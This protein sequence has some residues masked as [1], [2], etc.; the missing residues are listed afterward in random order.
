MQIIMKDIS[1]TI[2]KIAVLAVMSA[3]LVAGLNAQTPMDW[4]GN[5][6][7]TGIKQT[8][9]GLGDFPLT[10]MRYIWDSPVALPVYDNELKFVFDY[11]STICA[12]SGDTIFVQGTFTPA[13]NEFPDGTPTGIYGNGREYVLF[14]SVICLKRYVGCLALEL[15]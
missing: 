8:S 12:I 2:K 11:H 10:C 14:P 7:G 3:G 13:N 15:D 6:E 5:D 9:F 4:Y 1:G